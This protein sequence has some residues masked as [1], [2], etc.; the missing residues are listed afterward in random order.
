MVEECECG[1]TTVHR[2]TWWRLLAIEV[3]RRPD[4]QGVGSWLLQYR[5]GPESMVLLTKR[6]FAGLLARTPAFADTSIETCQDQ[7][8]RV[9][10]LMSHSLVVSVLQP[11]A[12]GEY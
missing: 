7:L 9:H 1:T 12:C 2:C 8:K 10:L 6:L 4:Y 11:A 3:R 5:L